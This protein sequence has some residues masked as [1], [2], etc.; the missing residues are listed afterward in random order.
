MTALRRCCC[1]MKSRRTHLDHDRRAALFEE[2]LALGSQAWLTGTDR[3][4]F[5]PLESCAQF[6]TIEEG[7]FVPMERA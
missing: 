7:C 6:F 2:I 3:G 4:L 5:A 1:S